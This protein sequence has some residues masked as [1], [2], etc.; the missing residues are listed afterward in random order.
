MASNLLDDYLNNRVMDLRTSL[1]AQ[2][3]DVVLRALVDDQVAQDLPRLVAEVEARIG[4]T[5][6]RLAV[7]QER[8]DGA[9]DAVDIAERHVLEC[10]H[11]RKVAYYEKNKIAITDADLAYSAAEKVRNDAKSEVT[12]ASTV[13]RDIEFR[14]NKLQ[15]ALAQLRPV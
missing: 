13:R 3:Q 14:L 4:A 10:D 9:R 15:A 7:A 2:A 5:R 1:R 6:D 8:E 11:V 12:T